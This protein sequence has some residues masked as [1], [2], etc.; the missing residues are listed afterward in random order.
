M[1]AVVVGQLESLDVHRPVFASL[2]DS[3]RC[4]ARS[5]GEQIAE[6]FPHPDLPQC[7]KYG[8]AVAPARDLVEGRARSTPRWRHSIAQAI[9]PPVEM[10]SIPSSSQSAEARNTT[11]GSLT[12]QRKPRANRGSYSSRAEVSGPL[13][14]VR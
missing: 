2:S 7:A 9:V 10:A 3:L 14:R 5:L 8:S 1:C 6:P 11:F 13:S 12:P 4:R